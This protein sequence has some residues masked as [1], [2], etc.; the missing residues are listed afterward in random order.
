[1]LRVGCGGDRNLLRDGR[2]GGARDARNR[3][4]K[5]IDQSGTG[6]ERPGVRSPRMNAS[7]G[8]GGIE[9]GQLNGNGPGEPG[10]RAMAAVV[11]T[12]GVIAGLYFGSSILEPF[13][14][15]V[16]LSLM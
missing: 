16:L 10:T 7:F 15:A 2:I 3:R 8:A 9:G 6:R 13:A 12:A 5:N 11:I 14:L 4:V 1:M